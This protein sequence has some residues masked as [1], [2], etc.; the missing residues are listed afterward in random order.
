MEMISLLTMVWS[1]SSMV[2]TASGMYLGAMQPEAEV[3]IQPH[4]ALWTLKYC[5]FLNCI[6]SY[7]ST[8]S[9][10]LCSWGQMVACVVVLWMYA[11]MS[12]VCTTRPVQCLCWQGL[13]RDATHLFLEILKQSQLVNLKL[14]QNI[15]K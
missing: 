12:Y 13:W 4:T 14:F 9:S 5:P 1:D 15:F 10:L 8:C 2:S 3:N 11:S 7:S 6:H